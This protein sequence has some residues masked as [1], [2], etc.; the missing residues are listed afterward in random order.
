MNTLTKTLLIVLGIILLIPV[1]GFVIRT[2]VGLL[3]GIVGLVLGI[4][5]LPFSFVG[6]LF[7]LFIGLLCLGLPL[8]LLLG[9]IFLGVW[10]VSCTFGGR[11]KKCRRG[12]P[13]DWTSLR[14]IQAGLDKMEE[15]LDTLETLLSNR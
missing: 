13:S 11:S 15:R 10:V 7:G 4:L 6:G 2:L 3:M 1:V 12:S 9:I 5:A 14:D 8:L